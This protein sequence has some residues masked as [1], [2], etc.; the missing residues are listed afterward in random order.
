[1][2]I[3][4]WL[5]IMEASAALAMPCTPILQTVSEQPRSA[6]TLHLP[7]ACLHPQA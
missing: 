2:L 3:T 7:V 4:V 1:M 6:T 5:Q